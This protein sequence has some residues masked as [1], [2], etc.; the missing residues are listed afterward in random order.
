MLNTLDNLNQKNI[1]FDLFSEYIVYVDESGD[2]GLLSIDTHYPVFV[3][4]FCIFKKSDYA[5]M[6]SPMIRKLKFKYFGHDMIILH[7]QEIRKARNDFKFLI[8]YEN[9]KSFMEDLNLLIQGSPFIIIA[10]AI[11]KKLLQEK[12]NQPSNPYYLAMQFG[13]E[14]VY[15]FMRD[16]QQSEK[17]THILF[18]SRG[19]KE[20]SDLEFEFIR[21]CGGNNMWNKLLPFKLIFADKRTNSCGLQ[22]ADL[23]ARP[24]GRYVL[25]ENQENRA[26][27][28]IREKFYTK[29]NCIKGY[30]LK[31]FP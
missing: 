3:L 30:G 26:L 20:D 27:Q 7:E 28:I 16:N 29:N 11:K 14:R 4:A 23:I 22:L 5:D 12:Y 15:S 31:C 21:T 13:L 19:K 17:I 10:V 25:E 18:E 8:N 24:I 1:S 9:R 2:H 6:I